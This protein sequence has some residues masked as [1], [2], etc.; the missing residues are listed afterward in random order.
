MSNGRASYELH[1]KAFLYCTLTLFNAPFFVSHL[2]IRQGGT[3][4]LLLFVLVIPE[5]SVKEIIRAAG[6]IKDRIKKLLAHK[7]SMKKK[8]K[9]KNVITEPAG[10]PNPKVN[11]WP[12]DSEK[13]VFR[14]GHPNGE[15]KGNEERKNEGLGEEKRDETASKNHVEQEQWLRGDVFCEYLFR[16]FIH[17]IK[18]ELWFLLANER[19]KDSFTP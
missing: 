8:V 17:F 3:S 11:L 7:N 2:I 14:G 16:S 19:R 4:C 10:T 9:I 1:R 15:I 5:K 13:S 18:N 12:F 6:T